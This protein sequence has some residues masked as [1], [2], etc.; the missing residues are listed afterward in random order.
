[1]PGIF[2]EIRIGM[3]KDGNDVRIVLEDKIRAASDD[4]AGALLSQLFDNF[5]LVVKQI[6]V[7]SKAVTFRRNQGALVHLA[8]LEKGIR[9]DPLVDLCEQVLADTAVLGSHL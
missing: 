1:M 9:A 2:A 3:D 5:R 4:D 7:R 6:G 8:H